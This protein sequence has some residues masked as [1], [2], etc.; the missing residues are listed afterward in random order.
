M[1]CCLFIYFFILSTL[2]K[3][4]SI[5]APLRLCGQAR[6]LV[7]TLA[8]FSVLTGVTQPVLS[9]EVL[10]VHTRTESSKC[11]EKHRGLNDIN[12]WVQHHSSASKKHFTEIT[13][14]SQNYIYIYIK[15]LKKKSVIIVHPIQLCYF[16]CPDTF[17]T[18]VVHFSYAVKKKNK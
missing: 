17:F 5:Y 7:T 11:S 9:D 6:I 3:K 2:F 10:W 16:V 12:T 4:S 8:L 18:P 1:V 13:L 14:T 15:N